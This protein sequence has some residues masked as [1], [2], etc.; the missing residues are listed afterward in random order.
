M[1]GPNMAKKAR[2]MRA[3]NRPEQQFETSSP[4]IGRHLSKLTGRG[5]KK[6]KAKIK[7][8]GPVENRKKHWFWGSTTAGNYMKGSSIRTPR[9]PASPETRSEAA[10]KPFGGYKPR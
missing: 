4:Q 10:F 7:G 5:A 2:Q 6:S 9:G 8:R 3:G 1:A